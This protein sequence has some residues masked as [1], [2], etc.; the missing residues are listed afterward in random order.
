M[1]W[2]CYEKNLDENEKE[3]IIVYK[4]MFLFN[5][6][7]IIRIFFRVISYLMC[8]TD[9][10]M[11]FILSKQFLY[12]RVSLSYSYYFLYRI[13]IIIFVSCKHIVFNILRSTILA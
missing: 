6:N 11:F 13:L 10:D 9:F 5:L 8:Y 4:M 7:L 12:I 3:L 2:I 1:I